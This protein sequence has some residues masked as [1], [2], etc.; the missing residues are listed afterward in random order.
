MCDCVTVTAILMILIG[1][2]ITV[3]P[4]RLSK[5]KVDLKQVKI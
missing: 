4:L 1:L 5:L 3:K 2:V